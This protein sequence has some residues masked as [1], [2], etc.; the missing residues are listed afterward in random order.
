MNAKL[1]NINLFV[2]DLA[3]SRAFYEQLIGLQVDD[4][5]SAPRM[6]ALSAGGC[7]LSLQPAADMN[8]PMDRI[9]GVELGF[10]VDT[11]GDV[12]AVWARLKQA[13]AD[14]DPIDAQSFG[15]TFNGRDPDGHQFV[16]YK[17]GD[18]EK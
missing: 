2:S 18:W 12:D 15:R 14:V 5:H 3:R 10:E 6:V 9:G 8:Q 4:R 11:A 7:S 16:V 13:G 1:S 17:L